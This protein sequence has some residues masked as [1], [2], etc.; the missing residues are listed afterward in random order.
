DAQKNLLQVRRWN[1]GSEAWI[2]FHFGR[3]Q[4]S[5]PIAL[6]AGRWTKA[7]DSAEA[8]WQGPGSPVAAE[9]ESRGE[10]ILNRPP[11]SVLVITRERQDI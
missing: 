7:L 6:S 4:E 1:S 2:M 8:Q 3:H 10:V 9:F 5:M 11:C